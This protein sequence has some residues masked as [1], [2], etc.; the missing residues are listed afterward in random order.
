MAKC[1]TSDRFHASGPSPERAFRSFA[2]A[3]FVSHAK[4]NMQRGKHR[5][6]GE[7]ARERCREVIAGRAEE[8]RG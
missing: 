8:L 6:R 2:V 1:A 7:V 4:A 3:V 5:E